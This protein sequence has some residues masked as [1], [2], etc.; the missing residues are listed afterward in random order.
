MKDNISIYEAAQD[1]MIC[2]LDKLVQKNEVSP[3]TLDYLDKIVDIIK[4][5]DEV[6]MN[7]EQRMMQDD[8]HSS[9][10]RMYGYGSSYRGDG[11]Y[12]RGSSYREDPATRTNSGKAG[13]KES[14]LNH[15]YAA[16]DTASSD[17]ERKRIKRMID[18]IENS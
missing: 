17:E 3:T 10:G 2:E 11:Y 15:L 9:R 8:G 12:R 5:L 6:C 1:M 18:E 13:S 4:D 7:E 16:H 14:M